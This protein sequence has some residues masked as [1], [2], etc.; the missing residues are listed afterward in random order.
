MTEHQQEEPSVDETQAERLARV[1]LADRHGIADPT[2]R[3]LAFAVER[4]QEDVEGARCV[5]G[6]MPFDA[7][8]R[9]R[10]EDVQRFRERGYYLARPPREDRMA[11]LKRA[12]S[13]KT[14]VIRHVED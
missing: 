13:G 4:V 14:V 11:V 1:I 12:G 3:D 10:Q 6:E 7:L 9:H 8:P 2:P 5:A